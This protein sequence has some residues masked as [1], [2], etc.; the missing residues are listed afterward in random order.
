MGRKCVE[1]Y[2]ITML[3]MVQH[4]PRPRPYSLWIKIHLCTNINGLYVVLYPILQPRFEKILLLVFVKSKQSNQTTIQRWKHDLWSR[5]NGPS[6]ADINQRRKNWMSTNHTEKMTSFL[7]RIYYSL[8]SQ[9][10]E[11]PA[12]SEQMSKWKRFRE[13]LALSFPLLLTCFSISQGKQTPVGPF[14]SVQCHTAA[15]RCPKA[16]GLLRQEI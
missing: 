5:G 11:S 15:H 6:L 4:I 1:K 13:Y 12:K 16:H 14:L 8:T 3:R 7:F 2:S 9:I 10:L